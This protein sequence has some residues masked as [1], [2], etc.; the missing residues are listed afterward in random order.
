MQ[1]LG[2]RVAAR[3]DARFRPDVLW[4]RSRSSTGGF[5]GIESQLATDGPTAFVAVNALII[6]YRTRFWDSR[7]CASTNRSRLSNRPPTRW[8]RLARKP[9]RPNGA[10]TPFCR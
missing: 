10:T 4:L 8:P 2:R 3:L 7:F 1:R 5:G 9:D 6:M